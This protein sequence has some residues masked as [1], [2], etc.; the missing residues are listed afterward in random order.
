MHRALLGVD[1]R[2]RCR[3]PAYGKVRSWMTSL[4]SAGS[5]ERL[6]LF[7]PSSGDILSPRSW[8]GSIEVQ[9]CSRPEERSR[10]H[11]VVSRLRTLCPCRE[12]HLIIDC[13]PVPTGSAAR[14]APLLPELLLT[15]GSAALTAV[16]AV[17]FSAASAGLTA[18]LGC[19]CLCGSYCGSEEGSVHR[20][21]GSRGASAP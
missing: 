11:R 10:C 16:T 18:G 6:I 7:S 3:S 9:L 8:Y 4:S 17:V 2:V 14:V 21:C 13:R 15:A 12:R 20:L 5:I 19:R 1:E